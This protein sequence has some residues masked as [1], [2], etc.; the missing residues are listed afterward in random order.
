VKP[1]SAKKNNV[2]TAA[3]RRADRRGW[4]PAA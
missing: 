2:A 4:Q 1:K 3:E